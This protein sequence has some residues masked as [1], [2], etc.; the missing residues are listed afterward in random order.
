M[1]DTGEGGVACNYTS[2]TDTLDL[3]AGGT[4]FASPALAGIQALVNQKT[5][6]SQGNPNY[7]YYRL[8]AAEYG[9]S[10]SASCNSD[11][12]SPK[13]PT[14]PASSCIFNDVT[15]GDI[16]VPCTGTD[17]CYGY[18]KARRTTYYGAL[19]TSS[20]TLGAAYPAGTGWDYA[21]GLGT[22]NAYNLVT[23]W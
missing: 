19:S 8:A 2:T 6:A 14:V 3:A 10:G 18:S 22:V 21:T 5:G 11:Q 1:S 7:T 13:S 12:G 16:D 17:D 23:N 15:A 4:S 20:S 9:A